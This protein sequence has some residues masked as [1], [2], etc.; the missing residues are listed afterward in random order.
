ML[1]LGAYQ[2]AL[3]VLRGC[4]YKA[5]GERAAARLMKLAW[6]AHQENGKPYIDTLVHGLH[7]AQVKFGFRA[8]SN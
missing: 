7:R 1:D 3:Y 8:V 4:G 5:N 2:Y 6:N